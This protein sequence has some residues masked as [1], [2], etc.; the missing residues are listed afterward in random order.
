MINRSAVFNIGDLKTSFSK[1]VKR[2]FWPHNGSQILSPDGESESREASN[3][4]SNRNLTE[5]HSPPLLDKDSFTVHVHFYHF[6][7]F[8]F[9]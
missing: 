9:S 6:I 2:G 3:S 8:L 5:P 1:D 4:R 7:F